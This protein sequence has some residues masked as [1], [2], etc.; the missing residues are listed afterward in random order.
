MNVWSLYICLRL[1]NC[2]LYEL[3]GVWGLLNWCSV[4]L[5]RGAGNN[6]EGVIV[7]FGGGR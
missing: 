7:L 4:V 6:H 2:C 1:A 5:M 3:G